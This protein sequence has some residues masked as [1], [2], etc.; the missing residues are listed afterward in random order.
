MRSEI[1]NSGDFVVASLSW[2]SLD[3][4]AKGRGVTPLSC[5]ITFFVPDVEVFFATLG[6]AFAELELLAVA[7]VLAIVELITG[8]EVR[9]TTAIGTLA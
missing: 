5:G 8:G 1:G 4:G 3:V 2:R 7:E 9:G 6:F